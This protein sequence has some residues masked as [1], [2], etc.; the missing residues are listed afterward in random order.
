MFL[1]QPHRL[2]RQP[3]GLDE[4]ILGTVQA[5][6]E[7]VQAASWSVNAAFMLLIKHHSL[8]RQCLWFMRQPDGLDGGILCIV[9]ETSQATSQR[10]S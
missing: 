6:T 1:N 7:T 10:E 5:T 9:K 3:G 4:G 2:L 8:L